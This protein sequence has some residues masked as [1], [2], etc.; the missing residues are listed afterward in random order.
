MYMCIYMYCLF[1][2]YIFI[3]LYIYNFVSIGNYKYFFVE[4]KIIFVSNDISYFDKS[5]E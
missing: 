1:L 4:I 3:L 2:L 5:L